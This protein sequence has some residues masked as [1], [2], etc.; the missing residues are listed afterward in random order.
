LIHDLLAKVFETLDAI[1]PNKTLCRAHVF[2]GRGGIHHVNVFSGTRNQAPG[3]QHT[4]AGVLVEDVHTI[5][6][7]VPGG[8]RHVVRMV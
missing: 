8:R 7:N 3:H 5:V 2:T 4:G 6:I 1:L